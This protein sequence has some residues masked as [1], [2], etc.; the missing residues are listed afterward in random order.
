VASAAPQ[1]QV[2]PS[3]VTRGRVSLGVRKWIWHSL[4]TGS[5]AMR[6]RDL[7][8]A[9]GV[10]PSSI[11]TAPSSTSPTVGCQEDCELSPQ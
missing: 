11:T 9:G 6:Q 1:K 3:A 4:A 5:N 2:T 7:S 8:P 10:G